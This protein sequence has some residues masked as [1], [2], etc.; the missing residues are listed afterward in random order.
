MSAPIA[1]FAY[2]RPDHLQRTVQALLRNSEVGNHDLIVFSD[3]ARSADKAAAVE[4]VRAY[5]ATIVGFRSVVIHH[6]PHNFGLAKSIIEG[7]TRVLGTYESVIVLEDDLVTS[8]YFLAYMNSALE[9]FAD[10][11]R[12][13]SIHGYV[14]PVTQV[15]PEAFFL[16]GAD[17]WGWATWRRG[18]ELFNA[19]GQSLLAELK[20]RKLIKSFNFNGAYSYTKMLEEQIRGNND[21]WAVRWYASAFLAGKLTLYPGRS[22]VHNI[23]NDNSGDHCGINTTYDAVLS[24]SPIDLTEISVEPSMPAWSAFELFFKKTQDTLVR[25]VVRRTKKILILLGLGS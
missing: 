1:L 8:P 5:L 24:L 18:W 9:K 11:A 23:G 12:V 20:R 16:P 3:A 22:L 21:S 10:D 25:K 15:L 4:E 7:V 2:A 13:I 19:D 17:C 6:R 14:Y